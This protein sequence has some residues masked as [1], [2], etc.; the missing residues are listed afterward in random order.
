MLLSVEVVLVVIWGAF[1][2]MWQS[3]VGLTIWGILY[4]SSNS[5]ISSCNSCLV[6][7]NLIN[8][9]LSQRRESSNSVQI[10]LAIDIPIPNCSPQLL[11]LSL[12]ASL[13]STTATLAA[14][15]TGERILVCCFCRSPCTRSHK[16]LKVGL[17]T[18]KCIF[19]SGS[20]S[21]LAKSTLNQCCG[22]GQ[23]QAIQQFLCQKPHWS[24]TNLEKNKIRCPFFR[25]VA[26]RYSSTRKHLCVSCNGK[27][28]S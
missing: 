28:L 18:W 22:W 12:V 15:L 3:S 27:T 20:M 16:A 17:G 13:H 9:S 4:S 1:I 11:K 6:N 2:L 25:C 19:Q 10:V 26:A 14:A 24:R 8:W 23:A 7:G 21:R 5:S